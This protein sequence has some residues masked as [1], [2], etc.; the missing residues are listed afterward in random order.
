[1]PSRQCP[2]RR[3]W[4]PPFHMGPETSF[5]MR[6][7]LCS[8]IADS[9]FMW[10]GWVQVKTPENDVHKIISADTGRRKGERVRRKNIRNIRISGIYFVLPCH[11]SN[12]T[13]HQQQQ[14]HSILFYSI[15]FTIRFYFLSIYL[16]F[17]VP[18]LRFGY[19]IRLCFAVADASQSHVA[20]AWQARWPQDV[21][22]MRKKL[23][24]SVSE[25]F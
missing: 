17:W 21:A 5:R 12:S 2:S 11:V 9:W 23:K 25:G 19:E 4:H 22:N 8:V 24:V 10:E 20:C 14:Q 3:A 1:M 16:L 15:Y 7:D 6:K 13:K 18:L